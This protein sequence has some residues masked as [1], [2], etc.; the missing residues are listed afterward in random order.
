MS[1]TTTYEIV[2][3]PKNSD[4]YAHDCLICGHSELSK[5]IWLKS[6]N[7]TVFPAGQTCASIAVLG[8]AHP[9]AGTRVRRQA[10]TIQHEADIAEEMRVERM[11]RFARA[12]ADFESDNWTADLISA[13]R[14]F[15]ASKPSVTFPEF[16]AQVAQTGNI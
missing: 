11:E 9:N 7:G 4:M 5:P 16:M 8:S 3:A 12:L 14:T 15:H 10:E 6:S 13:Q 1:M 2:P